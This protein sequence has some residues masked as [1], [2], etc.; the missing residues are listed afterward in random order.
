MSGS[1]TLNKIVDKSINPNN[2]PTTINFGN[3]KNVTTLYAAKI[4]RCLKNRDVRVAA[5][6]MQENIRNQ[7]Y[8]RSLIEY[9]SKYMCTDKWNMLLLGLEDEEIRAFFYLIW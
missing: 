9:L 3:N 8:R 2:N 4:Q 5:K 1:S 6:K 7:S